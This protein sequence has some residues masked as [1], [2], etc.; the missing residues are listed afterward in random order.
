MLTGRRMHGPQEVFLWDHQA[1]WLLDFHRNNSLYP[2]GIVTL[3][4]DVNQVV[5][6]NVC[7]WSPFAARCYYIFLV[8][9]C[10]LGTTLNYSLSPCASHY[11]G[12]ASDVLL[13]PCLLHPG[14]SSVGWV[15]CVPGRGLQGPQAG[16]EGPTRLRH[17]WTRKLL[18]QWE[19]RV[20]Y[21]RYNEP[22]YC[23][24]HKKFDH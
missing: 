2:A 24:V 15:A 19:L 1:T 8:I 14:G 20:A 23:L 12:G 5:N 11:S 4:C 18:C 16:V 22:R 10:L 7:G 13:L 9:I 17:R 6:W 3:S 21:Q